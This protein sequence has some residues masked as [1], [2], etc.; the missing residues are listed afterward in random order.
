VRR[1]P[2]ERS[3]YAVRNVDAVLRQ[4]SIGAICVKTFLRGV[5]LFL[6][7]LCNQ[8]AANR[9]K[10]RHKAKVENR[11]FLQ[12]MACDPATSGT[13]PQRAANVSFSA[14]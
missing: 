6:P 7:F 11:G 8:G 9:S 1:I 5:A 12:V 14:C 2:V 10:Q 13:R 3:I 4:N